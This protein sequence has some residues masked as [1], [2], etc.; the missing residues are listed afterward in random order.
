[1]QGLYRRN[2]LNAG[3]KSTR[4]PASADCTQL[5]DCNVSE[6]IRGHYATAV[7]RLSIIES[8]TM[9][10]NF[11]MFRLHIVCRDVEFCG[12]ESSLPVA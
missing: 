6:F 12:W 7:H 10:K 5:D 8:P 1:M 2:D 9:L 4:I 3:S 11:N